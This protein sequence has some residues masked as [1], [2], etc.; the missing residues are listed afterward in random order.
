MRFKN[1]I[2]WARSSALVMRWI[3]ILLPGV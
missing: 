1:A 3:G 2:K